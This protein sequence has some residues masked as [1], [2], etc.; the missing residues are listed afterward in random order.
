MVVAS[1]FENVRLT[2]PSGPIK[3]ILEM[4]RPMLHVVNVNSEHYVALTEKYQQER[5][6][7][8]EMFSDYN[9]E[10]YFIG[11]SDFFEGYRTVYH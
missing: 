7:M 6:I 10:F 8:L 2:T 5:A 11:M 3:T 1:D 9:P 4:F